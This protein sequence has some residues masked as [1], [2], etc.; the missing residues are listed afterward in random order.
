MGELGRPAG[1]TSWERGSWVSLQPPSD[2]RLHALS[3]GGT[4]APVSAPAL[5]RIRRTASPPSCS[6]S[7]GAAVPTASLRRSVESDQYEWVFD[8]QVVAVMGFEEG[9]TPSCSCTPLPTWTHEAGGMR[10]GWFRLSCRTWPNAD[11]ARPC[12]APSFART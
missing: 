2:P 4:P 10:P 5:S 8:D 6:S 7:S 11:P 12:G 9:A 3:T 1:H